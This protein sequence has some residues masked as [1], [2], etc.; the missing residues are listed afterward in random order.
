MVST[1]ARGTGLIQTRPDG[2]IT[3][4]G[5]SRWAVSLVTL[6]AAL[7]VVGFVA[8]S[9][10]EPEPSVV[11]DE[12]L[13]RFA[14]VEYALAA[15]DG[16]IDRAKAVVVEGLLF[17]E[18]A[19]IHQCMI[20]R[21]FEYPAAVGVPQEGSLYDAGQIATEWA[22]TTQSD[23]W[24]TVAYGVTTKEP[25]VQPTQDNSAYYTTLSTSEQAAYESSLASCASA[26]SVDSELMDPFPE[27]SGLARSLRDE[28]DRAESSETFLA[29][30]KAPYASC[31]AGQGYDVSDLPAL[32]DLVEEHASDVGYYTTPVESSEY[33]DVLRRAREWERSL[34]ATD[35]ACRSSVADAAAEILL[36]AYQR[37]EDQSGVSI[38]EIVSSWNSLATR[39]SDER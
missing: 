1:R 24:R 17:R 3:N 16:Q 19:E 8:C 12:A 23:T 26:A 32:I 2:G 30:V 38:Q 28:L 4:L 5:R 25:L 21:G 15:L 33:S 13:A 39:A 20:D 14:D 6:I 9:E 35:V 22:W 11:D 29:E 37:W 18:Q 34:A 31:M 36:P 27:A 10:P 7:L